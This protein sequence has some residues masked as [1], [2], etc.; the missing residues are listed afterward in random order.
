MATEA[1]S[2]SPIAVIVH[3]VAIALGL[4]L[5]WIAMQAISPDLPDP[6]VD[7]GVNSAAVIAGD[8]PDSLY[9][10]ANF[11]RALDQLDEQ[12]AAGEG[13]VSLHLEP[14][15]LET[16]SRAGEG[17]FQPADVPVEAP[18]MLIHSIDSER[19]GSPIGL[20]E[21]SYMDLVA[22]EDGPRWYVQLDTSRD[23]GSPPWTYGAPLEGA[24]L[25]VG[26]A[27]PQPVE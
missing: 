26:G 13:I 6:S 24:P 7:P 17:L 12:L 1:R 11:Q 4:Y 5:G 18:V 23:I 8:A 25:E 2:F 16:E 10:G 3:L 22:T 19:G 21:I 9:R 14:G 27:P 20:G 15:T